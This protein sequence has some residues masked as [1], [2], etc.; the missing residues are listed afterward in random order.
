[1]AAGKHTVPSQELSVQLGG[2]K[3]MRAF[4]VKSWGSDRGHQGTREERLL[5]QG[6]REQ[7]K[8]GP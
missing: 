3:S 2:N 1:V 8:K 7:W 5:T 6:T 4:D